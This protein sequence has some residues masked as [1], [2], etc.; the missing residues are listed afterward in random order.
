MKKIMDI[1]LMQCTQ[2]KAAIH[3]EI[4]DGNSVIVLAE[5]EQEALN[6]AMGNNK[7]SK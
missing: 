6:Q 7:S 5:E 1:L 2:E 3:K 4:I